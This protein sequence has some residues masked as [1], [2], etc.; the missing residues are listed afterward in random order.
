MD[1]GRARENSLNYFLSVEHS[2]NEIK[3]SGGMLV[4]IRRG[5]K[6]KLAGNL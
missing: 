6:P 2:I 5:I 3:D 1:S 4:H